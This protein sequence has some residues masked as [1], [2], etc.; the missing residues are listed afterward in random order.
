MNKQIGTLQPVENDQNI[1]AKLDIARRALAEATEDWQ[2]VDIR[3]NA[4]AVAAAAEILN[5]KDIQVQAANLV[6]DAER[7]IA[8]ANPSQTP[9]ES[10]AKK[11]VIPNHTLSE[12]ETDLKP[13]NIRQMRQAHSILS[14]EEHEA[15]KA[16][17]IEKQT[18]LTRS[19]LKKRSQQKKQAESRQ[20][21]YATLATF[22]KN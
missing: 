14:D 18:P 17:S 8:K 6:Q 21:R 20:E 2:R 4:R 16:E 13:H 19:E 22:Q 7:A 10:G 11:G 3:D 15:A 1:P 5:R 9:Q 12:T